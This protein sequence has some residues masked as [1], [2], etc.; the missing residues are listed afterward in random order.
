MPIYTSSSRP[1]AGGGGGVWGIRR[2]PPPWDKGSIGYNSIQRSTF[3]Y[4]CGSPLAETPK[5]SFC[6]VNVAP[7]HFR[8]GRKEYYHIESI[9]RA[10]HVLQATQLYIVPKGPLI[11][12]NVLKFRFFYRNC[13]DPPTHP[14][15]RL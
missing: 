13:S 12:I 1:V 3:F 11:I 6:W 8:C 7:S 2:P 15:F 5:S 9:S 10:I 14:K 4:S